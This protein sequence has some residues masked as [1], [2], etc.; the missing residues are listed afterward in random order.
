M[1]K[2]IVTIS[3]KGEVEIKVEGH[4]GPGCKALTAELEKKLGRT[5]ADTKTPDY[6]RSPDQQVQSK[7]QL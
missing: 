3:P 7:A 5:V 2:I 6:M 1:A 4:A